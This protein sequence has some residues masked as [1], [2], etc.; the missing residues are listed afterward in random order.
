MVA[1]VSHLSYI[2]IVLC[3]P[4]VAIFSHFRSIF[5]VF[6]YFP[7]SF[8]FS[9]CC[10]RWNCL[11][12]PLGSICLGWISR[13]EHE[14]VITRYSSPQQPLLKMFRIIL[15]ET[16]SSL[17]RLSSHTGSLCN[18]W[19]PSLPP[20]LPPPFPSGVETTSN[21]SAVST[22]SG[23]VM[24]LEWVTY[25]LDICKQKSATAVFGQKIRQKKH[26]FCKFCYFANKSAYIYTYKIT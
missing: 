13:G 24:I 19:V 18:S 22:F 4:G 8:I 12:G 16:T 9:E 6:P 11:P 26:M 5:L 15:Q 21:I 1:I 7:I 10:P 2:Y 3:F 20:S 25:R 14:E 17:V 23:A